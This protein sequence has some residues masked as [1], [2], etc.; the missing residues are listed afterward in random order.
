[1]TWHCLGGRTLHALVMVL[2]VSA[3]TFGAAALAPGDFTGE[4]RMDPQI[5]PETLQSMRDRYALDRPL[6]SRY[7]AWMNAAVHGD[8]GFSVTYGVPVSSL[9]WPRAKNTLLLATVA[10]AI[11]WLCAVPIGIAS[12]LY[13][14]RFAD[15]VAMALTSIPLSCSDLIIGLAALW[16]AFH[17]RAFPMGGMTSIDYDS[18]TR[19]E[20]WR[21]L[22]RHTTLPALAVAAIL[23]PP[24]A[25][26]IRASVADAAASPH[27]QAARAHGLPP[28]MLVRRYVLPLAANT[29]ISLLGLSLTG[30]LSASLVIEVVMGW[31]GLGPLLLQAT[32]ARDNN[33][34]I[35]VVL[36]S[37]AL[38]WAGSLIADVLLHVSDPRV[39]A[40]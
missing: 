28:V 24:L 14:G 25:R 34:V 36:V 5:S 13:R 1:M 27:V 2:V 29:Q 9:I 11:A 31:P 20:Q 15:R 39:R 22:I 19:A 17:T 10:T 12:G 3:L 33:V 26:Q 30:L 4:L 8:L 21:D 16:L 6:A 23:L 7:A 32:L 35:G 37:A 18:M 38:V 40:A